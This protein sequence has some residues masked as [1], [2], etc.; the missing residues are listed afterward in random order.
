MRKYKYMKSI[1]SLLL[2][3]V[4]ILSLIILPASAYYKIYEQF[5]VTDELGYIGVRPAIRS[6]TSATLDG[7]TYCR[8]SSD[9]RYRNFGAHCYSLKGNRTVSRF[10]DAGTWYSNYNH[11]LPSSLRKNC[12]KIEVSLQVADYRTGDHLTGNRYM[13][14]NNTYG[15][16]NNQSNIR[17]SG[18]VSVF[19]TLHNYYNAQT[20]LFAYPTVVNL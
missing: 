1:A 8:K 13:Y 20:D 14:E 7:F 4:L 17:V 10:C 9:G 5:E 6:N 2:S 3:S 15:I 19:S 11:D 16:C 18:K 12:K